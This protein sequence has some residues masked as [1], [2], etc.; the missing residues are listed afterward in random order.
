MFCSVCAWFVAY[1]KGGYDCNGPVDMA[2]S[3]DSREKK[4]LLL[5]TETFFVNFQHTPCHKTCDT[6]PTCHKYF[7]LSKKL[8]LFWPCEKSMLVNGFVSA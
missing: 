3:F 5:D 8:K 1:R 6:S 7:Q 2:L 4:N